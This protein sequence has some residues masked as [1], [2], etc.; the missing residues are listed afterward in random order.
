MLHVT[1]FVLF[2]ITQ[3]TGSTSA[4]AAEHPLAPVTLRIEDRYLRVTGDQNTQIDCNGLN[5]QTPNE[6]WIMRPIGFFEE[7]NV[8][9]CKLQNV[10]HTQPPAP[11]THGYLT[12]HQPT[13][14]A[15]PR[16]DAKGSTGPWTT[17]IAFVDIDPAAQVIKGIRFKSEFWSGEITYVGVIRVQDPLVMAMGVNQSMSHGNF[18][19][20]LA[21]QGDIPIAMWQAAFPVIRNMAPQP[22]AIPKRVIATEYILSGTEV[23]GRCPYCDGKFT[24][25][26]SEQNCRIFRHAVKKIDGNPIDPHSSRYK[27][28]QMLMNDEIRGCGGPIRMIGSWEHIQFE[29]C[30]YI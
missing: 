2:L 16:I 18:K 8:Y 9:I 3:F 23:I 13:A 4:S 27:I 1:G 17:L 6:Q 28:T 29:T 15:P 22:P 21:E 14:D 19:I 26:K 11:G 5:G 24:V 25:K 20:E 30:P 7:G 10:L 12:F